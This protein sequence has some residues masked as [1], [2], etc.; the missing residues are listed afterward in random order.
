MS[1]RYIWII[2]VHYRFIVCTFKALPDAISTPDLLGLLLNH[3]D[4][5]VGVEEALQHRLP[6]A[7]IIS[8]CSWADVTVVENG[9]SLTQ[10]GRDRF[11]LGTHL[12]DRK[13]EEESLRLLTDLLLKG[14][15][16]PEPELDIVAQRWR[17]VLWNAAYSSLCTASR[18]S[19]SELL[20]EPNVE[21]VND[22]IKEIMRE[23]IL[24][25]RT[26]GICTGTLLEDEAADIIRRVKL[27]DFKP[28]MLVDLEAGRPIE[29]EVIFGSVVRKA[30][31]VGV[32]VPRLQ[33]L[34]MILKVI[35]SKILASRK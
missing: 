18:T 24:V 6:T 30:A 23:V 9:R 14:G 31:E 11:T 5:G 13:P 29:V 3:G 21:L 35:Q 28:S 2:G 25:A 4:N 22:T 7:T 34:Y 15:A 12:P 16:K 20:A 19:I 1:R 10:Y 33:T 32:P 8:G 27:S 26:S 17:K